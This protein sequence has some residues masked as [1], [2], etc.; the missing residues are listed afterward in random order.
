[1]LKAVE[2]IGRIVQNAT[3]FNPRNWRDE[4]MTFA[5]GYSPV[6]AVKRLFALLSERKV[7][8]VLVGGIALLYYVEGRNT[9]DLDF[10]IA[11][12]DL[13]KMPEVKITEQDNNFARGDEFEEVRANF[14]FTRNPLFRSVQEKY[15]VRVRFRGQEVSLGTVEGLLLLKLYALLSLYRQGDFGRVS[16]YE[17]DI[18]ALVYAYAPDMSKLLDVVGEYLGG[19]ERAS[20]QEIVAEI[21][22]RISRFKKGGGKLTTSFAR[23]GSIRL[24]PPRSFYRRNL[25]VLALA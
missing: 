16:L 1:M 22:E 12:E 19:G 13:D 21:E 18:A 11:H 5:E 2:D 10:V 8:Y 3:L 25:V 9:Q 17:N 15:A 20:L 7:G 24:T 23:G 4:T 6:E 14:Y